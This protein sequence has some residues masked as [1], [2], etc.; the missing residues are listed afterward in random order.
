MPHPSY[1]KAVREGQKKE[2]RNRLG[3]TGLPQRF[4]K[5]GDIVGPDVDRQ[6]RAQFDRNKANFATRR[7]M[8]RESEVSKNIKAGKTTVAAASKALATL[9]KNKA[10]LIKNARKTRGK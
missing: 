3:V 7:T 10:T 8:F 6:M 2:Q 5:H 9:A 1:T 4:D